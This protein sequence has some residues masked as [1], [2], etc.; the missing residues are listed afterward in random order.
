[1]LPLFGPTAVLTAPSAPAAGRPSS[2]SPSGWAS[3]VEPLPEL[4]EEEFADDPEAGLAA[5]ERLLGRAEPGVTV[6][7]SQ[8][9]AIP[10]VLMALGVRR[11]GLAG[12][13]CP[14]CAKGSVWV[15]GGRPGGLSADYYRELSGHRPGCGKP[16]D[17]QRR[18]HPGRAG[19]LEGL[20]VVEVPL[21]QADVVEALEQPPAGVLV[22][23]ERHDRRRRR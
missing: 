20:D 9:G 6:V 19:R 23:L 13:L 14:P 1:M 4:G 11:D 21:G 8:G 2:R 15:L 12:R 18:R 17:G 16:R 5:V 3:P 7:C 22:D 10:S